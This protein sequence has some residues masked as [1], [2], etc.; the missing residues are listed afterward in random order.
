MAA[1]RG[2]PA[3]SAYPRAVAKKEFRCLLSSADPST[4]PRTASASSGAT[5][6]APGSAV[7]GFSSRSEARSWF[8]DV[9]RKRMRGEL[10]SPTPLTLAELVDEYLEQHVAEANTIRALARPAE[11]RDG[12]NP[13]EAAREGARA[14]P[15]RDPR[16]PARRAHGRRVAEAAPRGVRVARTQGA[17][18]GARLRGPGEARRRER[19]AGRAEPGAEAAR[20]AGV[21]HRG[22]SSSGSPESS[23][24][25]ERRSRS[26]VAGTGLR[27]EE[28]LALERRDV[29]TQGRRPPRP[30]RLHRRAGEGLRQAGTAR[31]AASR[32]AAASSR[33]SR[34]TRGGS[35]RCSCTPATAA[36]T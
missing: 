17:A 6:R 1:A 21:R 15:R 3:Q 9:E 16:R 14:R 35:T 19:R 20:G 18:P 10:V 8:W 23:R 31:S 2:P 25:R 24:R 5:R 33:R 12:R 34:R 13:G 27:P 4:R 28:W 29:D 32:S 26:L 11:A 22:R 7:P 36:A 30:P